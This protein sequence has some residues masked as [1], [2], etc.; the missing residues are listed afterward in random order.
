MLAKYIEDFS[1][2]SVK[3][4]LLPLLVSDKIQDCNKLD[5]RLYLH[6]K[7]SGEY[8]A[9]PGESAPAHIYVRYDNAIKNYVP[10]GLWKD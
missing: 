6:F 10:K 4:Y 8:I 3:G 5:L 1:S 9:A 7:S 2:E